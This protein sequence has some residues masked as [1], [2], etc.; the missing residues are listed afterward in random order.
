[1]W[2]EPESPTTTIPADQV[3]QRGPDRAPEMAREVVDPGTAVEEAARSLWGRAFAGIWRDEG[4]QL[5]VAT[6][7]DDPGSL[8]LGD[9]V[10]HRA[11]HSFE[12]LT[13]Y[14]AKLDGA[15]PDLIDQGVRLAMWG[16]SPA[17]N[18]VDV[19]V[20]TRHEELE[21]VAAAVLGAVG[22]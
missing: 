6:T 8:E 1:P 3:P 14:H 19:F 22:G 18:S 9:V 5:H 20:L 10:S 7:A 21:G 15:A 12:D 16:V 4:G 17:T 2:V 13:M 11:S